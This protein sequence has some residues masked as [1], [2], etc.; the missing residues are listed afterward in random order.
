MLWRRH[1]SRKRAW[2]QL[3]VELR[4]KRADTTVSIS[5][6]DKKFGRPTIWVLRVSASREERGLNRKP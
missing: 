4:S 1:D 6:E 5:I 3:L 2:A